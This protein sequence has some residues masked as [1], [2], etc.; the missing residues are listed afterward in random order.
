MK[1]IGIVGGVAWPS[2]VLLYEHLC[3]RAEAMFADPARPGP[4]PMPEMSIESLNV[5]QSFERRGT[6]GDEASWARYDAYFRLAL[7]RLQAS[8]ADFAVIAS[9]TPHNRWEAI[10]QGL[11]MPVLNIFDTVSKACAQAGL[12]DVLILGTA[13]TLQGEGLVQALAAQGVRG[14]KPQAMYVQQALFQLIL[15]LQAGRL[16]GAEARMGEIAGQSLAA[17]Q[18]PPDAVVGV[19]LCCTELPLAFGAQRKQA[20]IQSQGLCWIN[21]AIVHADAAFEY[22]MA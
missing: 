1:K 22:A 2:T 15:D 10:T 17:L 8:A 7:L 9:N 11:S 13:P 4:T 20:W 3:E 21:T 5:Q 14:H 6:P 16:D 18:L 12:S 19:G